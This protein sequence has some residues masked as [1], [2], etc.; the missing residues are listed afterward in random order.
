TGLTTVSD[1]TLAY[2][3]NNALSTGG[4]TVSGGTLD[5]ATYNDS[6]GTV[7][8]TSGNITGTTGV[9]T[10]TGTFEMQSGSVSAILGGTSALNKTTTG[11][12]TLSGQNTYTGLTTVSEGTLTLSGN[13]TVNTTGGYT[14]GGTGTQTLNIQNG[15]YGI[16]GTFIVGNNGGTATVNHSAG[17]ISSVGG[18]GL[19]IGNGSVAG[20]SAT[21]NLSGGSLTSASIIMGVNAGFSA[22]SPNT[23]TINVSGDG[24]LTVGTLRIGRNDSAGSFNT[25]STFNQTAG[26]TTVS[27]LGLGGNSANAANS[28]GPLIANLNLTGGTFTA[29][30][31][32][33]ISA[34][35][36]TTV[37]NAN[38]SFINIGGTAQV[39]LGTFGS[40]VKG[41]NSTATITFD[42]TTGG[43]GF[44]A[45]VAA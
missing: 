30:S 41:Q 29:T 42:T 35:G 43:G 2:G 24:A 4:V 40:I 16:G 39:T 31:I 28:T 5:L 37:Q 1:G 7:T 3:V 27:T 33:S 32:A 17:T 21:Y 15:N 6:V 13:R 44:L 34:G 25:T 19:I 8:L 22:A 10:S 38:S 14:V 26:T 45:P 9:L 18:S 23:S 11:T 20:T 12:V 36:A